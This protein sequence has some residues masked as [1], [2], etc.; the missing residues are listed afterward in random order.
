M[1]KIPIEVVNTMLP[2]MACV[3]LSLV[4]LPGVLAACS[5]LYCSTKYRCFTDWLKQWLQHQKQTGLPC[6]FCVA[7]HTMCS[8]CL[9]MHCSQ[10]YQLIETAVNQVMG[11]LFRSAPVVIFY[12]YPGVV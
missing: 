9:S 11:V 10:C 12:T 1:Y 2:C 8:V 4:Y 5:Q 7:L 3:M 6:F